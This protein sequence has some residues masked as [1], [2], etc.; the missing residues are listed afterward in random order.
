MI[1]Q[2]CFQKLWVEGAEVEEC[3]NDNEMAHEL[4]TVE[5]ELGLYGGSLSYTF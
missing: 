4:V 1:P 3:R 5:V 2:I